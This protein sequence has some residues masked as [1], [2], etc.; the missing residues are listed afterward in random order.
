MEFFNSLFVTELTRLHPHIY[1]CPH[2]NQVYIIDCFHLHDSTVPHTHHV[3][4]WFLCLRFQNC[5]SL[6]PY[7]AP[8]TWTHVNKWGMSTRLWH[9][10][11]H[12]Q[13]LLILLPQYSLSVP[14]H[15][16]CHQPESDLFWSTSAVFLILST[17]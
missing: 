7:M 15:S 10:L 11:Q 9:L 13:C 1:K 3:Q 14:L 16:H 2:N 6:F 12:L 4:N 5:V 17:D 8:M